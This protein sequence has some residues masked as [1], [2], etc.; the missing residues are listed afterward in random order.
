MP[1]PRKIALIAAAALGCHGIGLAFHSTIASSLIEF[2]MMVLAV[3]PASRRAAA[4][5]GYSRRFWRLM[6]VGFA[7]YALG[8]ALA[9]VLR[10]RCC[11]PIRSVVAE[12][13]PLLVSRCADGGWL[14]S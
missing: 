13:R 14:C 2:L 6:G 10:Q 4:G 1:A 12:R 7:L 9:T 8:Q 5:P 3:M 11:R